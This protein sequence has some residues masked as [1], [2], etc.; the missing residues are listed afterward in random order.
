MREKGFREEGARAA[1]AVVPGKRRVFSFEKRV[2]S[3]R[4]RMK[5][6]S[7]R[8]KSGWLHD[9]DYL[10]HRAA[11]GWLSIYKA[12][13]TLRSS[14][15]K[16]FAEIMID[17]YLALP[18]ADADPETASDYFAGVRRIR[19]LE[20]REAGLIRPLLA[21]RLMEELFEKRRE[22]R[23]VKGLRTLL[24]AAWDDAEERLSDVDEALRED[25]LYPG[26]DVASRKAWRRRIEKRASLHRTSEKEEALFLLHRSREEGKSLALLLFPD[27]GKTAGLWPLLF[28]LPWLFASMLA[29]LIY[30]ETGF[31]LSAL[32]WP[33]LYELFAGITRGL[34]LS[35]R[36]ERPLFGMDFSKGIPESE[37][38]LTVITG[39]CKD[40]EDAKKL[41]ADLEERW[42]AEGR[43]PKLPFGLLL[44]RPDTASPDPEEEKE[45]E[46]LLRRGLKELKEKYHTPFYGFLRKRVY[47]PRDGIYRGKERKRGALLSLLSALRRGEGMEGDLTGEPLRGFQN[48]VT[49]DRDTRPW[50][51]SVR[52]LVE[53]AAHPLNAPV[54]RKGRIERGYAVISPLLRP[55]PSAGEE[56]FFGE[57]VSAGCGIDLYG[58]QDRD[59][60]FSLTGRGTYPGKGLLRI[61]AAA[62][63]LPGAFP[64]GKILSHDVPEGGLLGT[65]VA[66]D[67]AFFEE[68]PRTAASYWTRLCR[69]T[70]GDT[71]NLSLLFPHS[72][73][74]WNAWLI[75]ENLR[76]IFLKPVIL[77]SLIAGA[78]GGKAL[79]LILP[80]SLLLRPL[81]EK[82]FAVA[83]HGGEYLERNL[84]ARVSDLERS[85]LASLLSLVF[86]PYE[87]VLL[88]G[89]FLRAGFRLLI[90]GK[91]LLEWSPFGGGDWTLRKYAARLLPPALAAGLFCPALLP[92]WLPGFAAAFFLSRREREKPVSVRDASYLKWRTAD[93]MELYKKLCRAEWGYL[94]ADNLQL[95]PYKGAAK[96][97]S[98]TDM[99]MTLLAFI[100]FD[101]LGLPGA[102]E[103]LKLGGE[104][105]RTMET[106]QKKWGLFY[107]W[108]AL[109][110]FD[111]APPRL[112]SSVD[113][114]NLAASLLTAAVAFREKGYPEYA[115]LAENMALA[116]ELER[117]YDRSDRLF[118][119][120]YDA[121]R[122]ELLENRYDLYQSEARILSFLAVALGRVPIEH[123]ER[124]GRPVRRFRG[125]AGLASWSGTMFESLLPELFL[126]APRGT[127]AGEGGS[128]AVLMQKL[129]GDRRGR[130][131]GVSESCFYAFDGAF[132]YRYKAHGA[133][134]L[135]L[136]P[137]RTGEYVIAPYAAFLALG[138]EESAVRNLRYIE[139]LGGVGRFGFY[140]ALDASDPER[141]RP[142][143][144]YMSH[145]AGMLAAAADEYLSHGVMKRRFFSRPEIRAF[146]PLLWETARHGPAA[147]E[148][149]GEAPP[150]SLGE[151]SGT[152]WLK[153]PGKAGEEKLCLSDGR[154]DLVLS[155]DGRIESSDPLWNGL[156]LYFR[157][158][159]RRTGMQAY[160]YYDG[161]E[162]E[163]IFTKDGALFGLRRREFSL[164]AVIGG[165][166][167]L[168][169][170]FTLFSEGKLLSGI[171]VGLIRET[172]ERIETLLTPDRDGIA[173]ASLTPGEAK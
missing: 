112:L 94:P 82:A 46:N 59:L 155:G 73:G 124:L 75:T 53:K 142:V 9:N 20:E 89:A 47:A 78:A 97:T 22:E 126:P 41:I 119:V 10:A 62:A 36:E 64:E 6:E 98:P 130:P 134:S 18:G 42:L 27:Y 28:L 115:G 143:R 108:Y 145:H 52:R 135:S 70:R 149:M 157:D 66:R 74:A 37:K 80:A 61:D 24:S 49:L 26:M 19:G 56:T 120:G 129:S 25:M 23:A 133:A 17:S 102:D 45:V 173:R 153:E 29:G 154:T 85:A 165:R 152:R 172:G 113:S 39:L 21:L 95:Y 81:L 43:D 158:G 35:G 159:E 3:L 76:R 162:R 11:A 15:G 32:A 148:T 164:E 117:L 38:T 106:L 109:P 171:A 146:R 168:Q 84:T 166:E 16:C 7:V 123:W 51:G 163:T 151:G 104:M 103:F 136:A 150:G 72:H 12:K 105:L 125:Y 101:D 65:A 92:V 141:I 99:G 161:E 110:S 34:L 156:A 87:T 88:L 107:N 31:L 68:E 44:D 30:T 69:W 63:L 14:E 83:L 77:L 100:A 140:E 86:L 114:G 91:K 48:L 4:K 132:S 160:P 137:R 147:E 33:M 1:R 67:A 55:S 167:R 139:E 116:M 57:I 40:A 111:P 128:F 50:P 54:I 138:K 60:L 121:D 58:G 2:R 170:T 127:L 144:A 13:H 71:Q 5:A 96:I 131:W 79:F 122:E 90:S 169:V 8:E 93:L 118:S